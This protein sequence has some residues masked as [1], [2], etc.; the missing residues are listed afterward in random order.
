MEQI[1]SFIDVSELIDIWYQNGM[2]VGKPAIYASPV[3]EDKFKTF[4]IDLCRR[5]RVI[6]AGRLTVCRTPSTV[7]LLLVEIIVVSDL[8]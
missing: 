1:F 6:R 8:M 2:N 5:W 4:E 7:I 3:L